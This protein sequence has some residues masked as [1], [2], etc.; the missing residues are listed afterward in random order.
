VVVS[1]DGGVRPLWTREGLVYESRGRLIRA[2]VAA[3]APPLRVTQLTPVTELR[4]RSVVGLAPDGRLLLHETA[5][6]PASRG[7]VSLEWV[8]D[9][10]SR[11]GP[12]VSMSR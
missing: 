10:R 7:V 9:V 8:R 6:A 3:D 11:L 12:A 4:D 1:T 5:G 2:M